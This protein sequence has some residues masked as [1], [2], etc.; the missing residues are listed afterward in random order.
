M[1]QLRGIHPETATRIR[2]HSQI[3]GMHAISAVLITILVFLTS[4]LGVHA[5]S[6]LSG[7][8]SPVL[9]VAALQGV[10]MSATVPDKSPVTVTASFASNGKPHIHGGAGIAAFLD[11][12]HVQAGTSERFASVV[13][14]ITPGMPLPAASSTVIL[15]ESSVRIARP[16]RTTDSG[17][18]HW[19]Q[20]VSKA[21]TLPFRA[22]RAVGLSNSTFVIVGGG[23]SSVG[24]VDRRGN[25]IFG[26][27]IQ[28]CRTL[29]VDNRIA[30]LTSSLVVVSFYDAPNYNLTTTAGA[31]VN[32][33]APP[34]RR[35]LVWGG[36]AQYAADH[37]SHVVARLSATSAALVF[38]NDVPFS[39]SSS[40]MEEQ[41]AAP[42]TAR[43]V[44]VATNLTT[45][46]A[47]IAAISAPAL[48]PL[49]DV[50]GP[51]DCAG[52]SAP[53]PSQG[54][55]TA[56][57]ED[58][59]PA[60]A[61]AAVNS[62]VAGIPA[63]PRA[64]LRRMRSGTSRAG[65]PA[66]WSASMDAARTPSQRR[67]GDSRPEHVPSV[68]CAFRDLTS[69]S[70]RA[71][72]LQQ[73]LPRDGSA[74]SL[75]FPPAPRFTAMATVMEHAAVGSGAVSAWRDVSVAR[76]SDSGAAVLF[77]DD[78][79]GGRAVVSLVGLST[80]SRRPS[81]A[82]SQAR[83]DLTERNPDPHKALFWAGIATLG[84]N[85][86][87]LVDW[88]SLEAAR[89]VPQPGSVFGVQLPAVPE[90]SRTQGGA[91][92]AGMLHTRADGSNV[93]LG[94]HISIIVAGGVPA[95]VSVGGMARA[96][97][98]VAVRVGGV[99]TLAV[100]TTAVGS[101]SAAIG[102]TAFAVPDGSVVVGSVGRTSV[103]THLQ[104]SWGIASALT[105]GA[106]GIA[107]E[108][109]VAAQSALGMII[110]CTDSHARVV[111][112]PGGGFG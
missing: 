77:S 96:G 68:L 42:L 60:T 94:G 38:P 41:A 7:D 92:H 12:E 22:E 70:L 59:T 81:L 111:L 105:D 107:T 6:W 79:H 76:M 18:G 52:V 88:A 100:D 51:F 54:N 32:M 29:S 20:I 50:D 104:H 11:V 99:A 74:A 97:E 55:S 37:M 3:T 83:F 72:L 46:L 103:L 24:T 34:S 71:V 102:H 25:V 27:A 45:G 23:N 95:G 21:F 82:I 56:S 2:K 85:S 30:A 106:D 58:G 28:F 93:A 33:H 75:A 78:D 13:G 110:A 89:G 90:A 35:R 87:M 98:D 73:P 44:T 47:S 14:L 62:G 48:L 65:I 43:V 80:H 64:N 84:S 9:D 91:G 5:R 19:K 16:I 8:A 31:V 63:T 40:A 57:D 1:G 17:H 86:V 108:V 53:L 61:P 101:C 10:A 15:T 36:R 66:A 39:E 49:S 26:P 67:G 109:V 112:H 4:R 69:G